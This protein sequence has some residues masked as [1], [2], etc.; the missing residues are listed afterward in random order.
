MF[1]LSLTLKAYLHFSHFITGCSPIT[2]I[3]TRCL[4][5]GPIKGRP[6]M[7]VTVT[8]TTSTAYSRTVN[9]Q[10]AANIDLFPLSAVRLLHDMPTLELAVGYCF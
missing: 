6:E 4:V 9:S 7:L 5:L 8:M 10:P 3:L 2:A 1:V